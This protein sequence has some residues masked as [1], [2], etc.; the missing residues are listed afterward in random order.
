MLRIRIKKKGSNSQCAD[1]ACK[2]QFKEKLCEERY[3]IDLGRIDEDK[4]VRLFK[5]WKEFVN[6]LSN[7]ER[8]QIRVWACPVSCS[9]KQ[10]DRWVKATK[11][12]LEKATK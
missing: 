7:D 10:I 1:S 2:D 3:Q 4:S 11:G 9:P 6:S 8:Q 5:R 12:T